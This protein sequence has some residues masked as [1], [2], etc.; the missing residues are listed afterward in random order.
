[1]ILP[2]RP[3]Y[4][5]SV[6]TDDSLEK[7]LATLGP[8]KFPYVSIKDSR[9]TLIDVTGNQMPIPKLTLDC[10]II[11]LNPN[12][13][14]VYFGGPY[15]PS[16]AL[17]PICWSDNGIAPSVSASQPQSVQ[18]D[19]CP[20][21]AWGS[22]VS[23]LGNDVK[24]CA[25]QRKLALYLPE[26]SDQGLWL[27][28]VPPNS[29]KNLKNYFLNFQ[30]Y[31]IKVWEVFTQI[32]FE[33]GKV[34]TL[35]FTSPGQYIPETIAP[36]VVHMV[37]S[38]AADAMIGML[39]RP[40]QGALP[41]PNTQTTI[42]APV[43]AHPPPTSAS[44]VQPAAST[45]PAQPATAPRK[46]GPRRQQREEAGASQQGISPQQAPFRPSEAPNF[47]ISADAPTPPAGLTEQLNSVFGSK[48]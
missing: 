28:R 36:T 38:H 35:T 9:F 1:M 42:A 5:G 14:K 32:S 22:A 33:A 26:F 19:T 30:K 20:H 7:A 18:C 6:P 24:A 11:A 21:D 45:S 29:L 46:R 44:F 4:L 8:S 23:A 47:G 48:S 37:T 39:D 17:P 12:R 31:Q 41:S 43:A 3:A 27:L 40:R 34:G 15:D 10:V 2:S 13:S 25:D 16:S